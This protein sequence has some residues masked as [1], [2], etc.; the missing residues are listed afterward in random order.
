MANP[1]KVGKKTIG[2]SEKAPKLAQTPRMVPVANPFKAQLIKPVGGCEVAQQLAQSPRSGACGDRTNKTVGGSE[3]G[4]TIGSKPLGGNQPC[5]NVGACVG[6][7][8]GV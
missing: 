6:H 7:G 8:P 2:D 1:V 4:P 3:K 5:T